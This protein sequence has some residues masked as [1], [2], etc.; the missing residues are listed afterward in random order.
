VKKITRTAAALMERMAK[1]LERTRFGALKELIVLGYHRIDDTGCDLSVRRDHFR[2]HLEWIDAAGVHVVSLDDDD[3]LVQGETPRVAFTFDDGYISVAESA[4]PELKTRRWPATVYAVSAYLGGDL[5]FP[6]DHARDER[7]SRLM[8]ES[9]LRELAADGMAIGSHSVTHRYLPSLSLDE[10]RNEIHRSK[11]ALEDLLE[12]N[13]SSFSYPMGGWNPALRDAVAEAGYRTA[14]TCLR[15]R[16]R[17]GCDPL[18]LRRPIVE[19]DPDDFA[20]IVKGYFDF[21]R[22]LDWWREKLRQRRAAPSSAPSP[23]QPSGS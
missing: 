17:A 10:S 6:W 1:P 13:V 18:L 19:S 7:S 4:W 23:R 16:N 15:G 2:A 20:R 3:L 11:R 9:V 21:L 12:R 22:P 14:V 8:D 5:R